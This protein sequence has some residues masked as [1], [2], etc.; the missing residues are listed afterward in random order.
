MFE[1]AVREDF[2]CFVDA[3]K[4]AGE[5]MG[6]LDS[7]VNEV[8]LTGV[9]L[10]QLT[11]S[12]MRKF[13]LSLPFCVGAGVDSCSVMASEAKGAIIEMRN[14]CENVKRCPCFNHA[15]NNSLAQ[16]SKVPQS[17]NAVASMKSIIRFCN[18]SA[19]RKVVFK[20]HLD[21]QFSGLCETRW[22]ERHDGVLQFRTNLP[23][24]V[25]A[26]KEI[27]KWND[28]KTASEAKSLVLSIDGEFVVA[29][30]TL[31][32]ILSITRPLSL[33]LQS[34]N[35]D[36]N[37]G[38]EALTYV[39]N[40]L[41][42]MRNNADNEFLDIFER[43]TEMTNLIGVPI[44]LPRIVNRQMY[45]DNHP[46]SN[47]MEYYRVSLFIPIL[48]HVIE[49]LAHRLPPE[50]LN[51]FK[52]NVFLPS[53]IVSKTFEDDERAVGD[54]AAEYQSILGT[55]SVCLVGEYKVWRN[56]WNTSG[57]TIPTSYMEI[58]KS[59]SQT[60]FPGIYTMLK[61]FGSMPVSVATAERTF[62]TL[63]RLKTW[64]RASMTEERLTGLALLHLHL[65]L[66]LDPE[67]IIDR[68]AND[69][70]RRMEFVI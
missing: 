33:L 47:T 70:A 56:K 66:E 54:L 27:S 52:L 26:L 44:E 51:C 22:T 65:D 37:T 69:Q 16:T 25:E 31:G 57:T 32:E 5:L 53:T 59:C 18:A 41:R 17:R 63:R 12:L 24:I 4:E 38:N 55:N 19:K 40:V 64:L 49:D 58:L 60:T 23:N 61:V 8:R 50:T 3:Y 35:I 28:P 42:E 45:R 7:E 46:V 30:F 6:S 29:T 36:L 68:F 20:R 13:G 48:D 67:K 11:V 2:I 21:K 15:L 1:D 34:K 10:G 9:A 39:T 14:S 43:S 62:S